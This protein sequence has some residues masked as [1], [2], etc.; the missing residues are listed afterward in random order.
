SRTRR[1]CVL[2]VRIRAAKHCRTLWCGGGFAARAKCVA[3]RGGR[4]RDGLCHALAVA[5][6]AA[7]STRGRKALR[8]APAEQRIEEPV[9][10]ATAIAG[11]CRDRLDRRWRCGP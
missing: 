8:S 5:C 9:V 2:I 7:R 6:D 4:G 1:R 11:R 3:A 10:E